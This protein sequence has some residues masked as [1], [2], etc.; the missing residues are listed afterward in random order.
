M[1]ERPTSESQFFHE[2]AI[3]IHRLERMSSKV[4]GAYMEWK[5][6]AP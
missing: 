2:F 4:D 5:E 3:Q 1:V 6:R